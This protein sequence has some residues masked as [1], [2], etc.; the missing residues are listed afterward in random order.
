MTA[1]NVATYFTSLKQYDSA[2]F[3]LTK[4][5]NRARLI[6]DANNLLLIRLALA[7]IY[8]GQKKYDLARPLLEN[9]EVNLTKSGDRWNLTRTFISLANLDTSEQNYQKAINNLLKG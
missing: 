6:N 1:T 5:E 9:C 2:L 3:Y 4:S 7:G 8:L